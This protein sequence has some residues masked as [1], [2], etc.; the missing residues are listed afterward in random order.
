M[1]AFGSLLVVKMVEQKGLMGDPGGFVKD[2]G[3][4]KLSHFP[5]GEEIAVG[6]E[7]PFLCVRKALLLILRFLNHLVDTPAARSSR[8]LPGH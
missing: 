4:E 5:V 8:D 7:I 1:P 2:I 6:E 3:L